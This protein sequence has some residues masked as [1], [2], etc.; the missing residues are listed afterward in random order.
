M[1]DTDVN[2]TVI[3]GFFSVLFRPT[4]LKAMVIPGCLLV[5]VLL[6]PGG[7]YGAEPG[8]TGHSVKT[9]VLDPGDPNILFA[10]TTSGRVAKSVNGGADWTIVDTE[11]TTDP[12]T[13]IVVNPGNTNVIYASG[14][15]A[16]FTIAK[17]TDGGA[18]WFRPIENCDAGVYQFC[19]TSGFYDLTI[20]PSGILYAGAKSGKLGT[21]KYVGVFKSNDGGVNWIP[22]TMPGYLKVYLA[23]D[24]IAPATIYAAGW[25]GGVYKSINSGDTWTAKNNGLGGFQNNAIVID[26]VD[27]STLYVGGSDGIAYKST[28]GAESWAAL[29]NGGRI[30]SVEGAG[31]THVIQSMAID[32]T[33]PDT[34]YVGGWEDHL[35]KSTD[36]GATWN[37]S[38]AG[39]DDNRYNMMFEI[40]VDPSDPSSVF[41]ATNDG[42][43]KSEDGGATWVTPP[44][45]ALVNFLWSGDAGDQ[46]WHKVL[47]WKDEETGFEASKAPGDAPGTENI[48]IP[49]FSV[50]LSDRDA[51]VKSIAAD[52][53]LVL[54]K[55]LT[56]ERPSSIENVTMG[57]GVTTQAL[58]TL[59]EDGNTW[60]GGTI[61]GT[62]SLLVDQN[63]QLSLTGPGVDH[64]LDN[65]MTVQGKVLHEGVDLNMS[66]AESVIFIQEEAEYQFK[67]GHIADHS[68]SPSINNAGVFLKTGSDTATLST[69]FVNEPTGT[70][71]V[72]NGSLVFTKTARLAGFMQIESPGIVEFQ[73]AVITLGDPAGSGFNVV[74]S[75]DA[76]FT[77][78]VGILRIADSEVLV[79]ANDS[80]TFNLWGGSGKVEILN[81]S[82]LSGGGELKN[83]GNFD[84]IDGTLDVKVVN[85]GTFTIDATNSQIL[86]DIENQAD[87]VLDGTSEALGTSI[88]TI[89]IAEEARL[90]KKGGGKIGLKHGIEN[91]GTV[92]VE[93]GELS[94]DAK[95]Y[96]GGSL[97]PTDTSRVEMLSGGKLHVNSLLN[98]TANTT[99]IEGGMLVINPD[100][101]IDLDS[102]NQNSNAT[103]YLLNDTQWLGGRF[104]LGDLN[105]DSW[106]DVNIGSND[107]VGTLTIEGTEPHDF[108][109]ESVGHY[110]LLD[111][112]VWPRCSVLQKTDLAIFDSC[113]IFVRGSYRLEG[114]EIRKNDP[115]GDA[116]VSIRPGGT[117]TVSGE[118]AIRLSNSDGG[119]F[120]RENATVRVES[121]SNFTV[122]RF[123]LSTFSDLEKKL[124]RGNW[125]LYKNAALYL[126]TGANKA[127]HHIAKGVSVELATGSSF[128]N[129]PHVKGDFLLEGELALIDLIFTNMGEFLNTG[130]LILD[131]G[132]LESGG[133]YRN[134]GKLEGNGMIDGDMVSNG[135]ISPGFSAG[136]ITVSGNFAQKTGGE[137]VLELGGSV[138]GEDYDQFVVNGTAALGGRLR[139]IALDDAFP[140]VTT[141]YTPI[142]AT[143]LQGQFDE[144]IYE[145]P[146]GRQ[147][148]DTVLSDTGVT[149]SARTL[150]VSTFAGWAAGV[151]TASE[152]ADEGISSLTADPDGDGLANLLEYALDGNPKAV[153]QPRLAAEFGYDDQGVP[154]TV[155]V[156]FPWANGM[157]DINYGLQV[158]TDLKGWTALSSELVGIEDEGLISRVTLLAELPEEINSTVFIQL[159]VAEN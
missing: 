139:L 61:D 148:L 56:L 140:E 133:M 106:C 62:G 99:T 11:E 63:A 151:F 89:K 96:L 144:V 25:A 102:G 135:Q 13:T 36:G 78:D 92:L 114:S 27:P 38:N 101:S 5:A 125:I 87:L 71:K 123:K 157:T 9:L 52:G 12:I 154:E 117:L 79:S 81:G 23:M 142:S 141:S 155:L 153:T 88:Q 18:T 105:S 73:Q 152:K 54:K 8:L 22:T 116:L 1:M 7:S 110:G 24:P 26:P 127:I 100:A 42:V 128:L 14:Y 64:A 47:N 16:G 59:N 108:G 130:K 131:G 120:V 17:S 4:L 58:L 86:Q 132:T 68:D 57:S 146:S 143:V 43:Y 91:K 159:I 30:G 147:V 35:Y 69:S 74:G 21:S 72:E 83:V 44:P 29:N 115:D 76:D 3:I 156:D 66:A 97:E 85:E 67:S 94:L 46:D 104:A 2:L 82:H 112:M 77:R 158:S 55:H 90:V 119:V 60:Q 118:S 41:V 134:E 15:A 107:R 45:K 124:V 75:P 93:N 103:L 40:V 32:P 80:A 109:S 28:D 136:T 48:F 10:G 39:L 34:I 129:L 98:C 37:L 84:L 20:G 51:H 138:P 149:V 6:M 121:D 111:M 145:V 65:Q 19:S 49:G 95:S 70:L 150:N 122:G 53:F 113:R 31:G 137:L 50:E 126:T 33:S